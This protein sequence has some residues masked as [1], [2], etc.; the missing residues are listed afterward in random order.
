M[1]GAVLG[2]GDSSEQ[3]A[4]RQ[5]ILGTVVGSES[6]KATFPKAEIWIEMGRGRQISQARMGGDGEARQERNTECKGP[7]KQ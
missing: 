6:E 5:P 7:E 4:G 1:P 3:V 2:A